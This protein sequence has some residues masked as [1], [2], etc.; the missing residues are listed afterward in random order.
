MAAPIDDDDDDEEVR[1]R[2]RLTKPD[3]A[4]AKPVSIHAQGTLLPSGADEQVAV[5]LSYGNG[6]LASVYCTIGAATPSEAL[7]IGRKGWIR[8]HSPL[9]TPTKLTVKVGEADAEEHEFPHP[10]IE[11]GSWFNFTNSIGMRH[12]AMYAQ[13]SLAVGRKESHLQ[14]LDVTLQMMEIMDEIRSQIGVKYP[15]E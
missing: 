1:A 3:H 7:I 13:E 14:P 10:K 8:V 9:W 15:C 12:E 2:A 6:R 4:D 5:T 11:E